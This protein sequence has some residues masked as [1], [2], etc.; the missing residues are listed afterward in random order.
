MKTKQLLILLLLFCALAP[1]WHAQSGQVASGGDASGS[2]GKVSY[3]V[4]Q[5]DY[6]DPS[7]SGGSV[8][9]GLQQPYEISDAT[10]IEVRSI[11]L[12][13]AVFPSPTLNDVSLKVDRAEYTNLRYSLITVDGKILMEADVNAE[14]TQIP[15]GFLAQ[16]LYKVNVYNEK[17][18][19]KSFNV[20]KN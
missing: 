11:S 6:M 19:V 20:I 16:G 18:L 3:S 4:G 14:I 2:G 9:Q 17:V 15:M 12:N 5:I 13:F 8:Y 7:G 1:G 10:G